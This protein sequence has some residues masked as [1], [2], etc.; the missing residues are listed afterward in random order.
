MVH[1]EP[2]AAAEALPGRYVLRGLV[3][4]H[5][6]PA[7][8][9]GP[10]GPVALDAAG[11]RSTLRAWAGSGVTLVRDVGSPAGLTLS[12]GPSPG[13]P[14]VR[15]AGRFL[16]PP[17]RYF[18]QLLVEPVGDG[19]LISAALAEIRRGASWVKVIADSP[20]VPQFSDVERTYPV[21]LIAR[22]SEAVHAAGARVAAHATLPGVVELIAAGVDSVEHGTGLD[23][24]A[25]E[26]MGRR[27][28]AWTPTLCAIQQSLDE[29]EVAPE[30]RQR[31]EE[32]RERLSEL[33][34]LAVRHKVAVLA[35]TDVVGSLPREVAL[36]AEFGLEPNEALAAASEWGRRFIDP[37]STR[38]D[39]VT[40]HDDPRNDPSLLARPAAVVIDGVRIA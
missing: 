4:A 22:L 14:A 27:G 25:V 17:D 39:I 20:R 34:P 16:A 1:D 35:G 10:D 13:Q 37:A 24:A 5:A 23:A 21:E 36:L 9:H 19:E 26:E 15:A 31:V 6:H 29:P 2:L 32:A 28:V 40:Y 18:P 8:T 3:D 33:L 7:V 11:T 12:V 38:A 30:K